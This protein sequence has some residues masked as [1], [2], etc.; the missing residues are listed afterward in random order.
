MFWNQDVNR[1]LAADRFCS[2]R[3][4]YRTDPRPAPPRRDRRWWRSSARTHLA[5]A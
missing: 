3:R 2:L 1:M 5:D 4:A